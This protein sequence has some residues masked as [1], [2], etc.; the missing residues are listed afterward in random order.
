[1]DKPKVT[2]KDFFLWAGAM[3]TLYASIVALVSLLFDYINYA[4][5]DPLEYLPTDPYSGGV[6]Y[7]MASLIVLFPLFILLMWLIRRD[8]AKDVTRGKVWVRRWALVLTLFIAV[9]AVAC[10]LITLIMYFLQGDLT[11]RFLLKVAVVLLVAAAGFMHFLA[12]MWGYWDL[13]PTRARSVGYASAVL[14]VCAIISRFIIFG[15][16]AQSRLY[17]FDEQ[18]VSDLQGIQSQ[19]VTYWQSKQK[20]PTSLADLS[21]PISGYVVPSDPQDKSSYLYKVTGVRSFELCA[22]FN[23]AAREAGL[24]YQ[25][26]PVGLGGRGISDNWYHGAGKAC[27]ERTIDPQLYPPITGTTKPAAK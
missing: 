3:V 18:K 21:D 22:T 24:Q 8:I 12:D 10:D 25:T 26:V 16:P 9:A 1:M 23:A 7:E 5:P 15:T 27:F 14:V 11:T 20:L 13:Y 19:L 6:A 17:R 2:P 4:F